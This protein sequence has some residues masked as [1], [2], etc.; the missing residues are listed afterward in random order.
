MMLEKDEE[1]KQLRA[2]LL[3]QQAQ[4]NQVRRAVRRKRA[5]KK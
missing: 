5:A 4:L 2:Q 3:Q 1:I